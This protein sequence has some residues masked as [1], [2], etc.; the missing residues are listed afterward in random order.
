MRDWQSRYDRGS[1]AIGIN[2]QVSPKLAKPFSH[3]SDSHTWTAK[4]GHLVLLL[5]RDALAIVLH[6]NADVTVRAQDTNF[7]GRAFRMAVNIGEAFLHHP[8]DGRFR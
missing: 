5:R 8:E 4:R 1:L 7:G 3:P 2:R 6:L